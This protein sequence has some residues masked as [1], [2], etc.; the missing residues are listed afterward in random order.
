[1]LRRTFFK[2]A[3]AMLSGVGLTK[4]AQRLR[5]WSCPAGQYIDFRVSR[6]WQDL[7]RTIPAC[8]GDPVAVI[9]GVEGLSFIQPSLTNQPR[10]IGGA[11][12]F[13]GVDTFMR[14]AVTE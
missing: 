5:G 3:A 6:C 13:N 10:M 12:R 14:Q 7:D 8:D 1:M 2:V 4:Q 9:E 11:V